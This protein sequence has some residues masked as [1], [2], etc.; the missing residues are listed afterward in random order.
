MKLPSNSFKEAILAGRRQ[1]GFWLSLGSAAVAEV[2]AGAGYD[3]VMIDA[4]H[5][6]NDLTTVV[7]QLRVLEGGSATPVVR[8]AWNDPVLIKRLLDAGAPTLLV[9]FVRNADE[10]A[11][12]V[13]ATRYPPAGIRGV[14]TSQR[15]SRWGQRADYVQSYEREL[16]VIV[17]LETASSLAALEAIALVPGIDALFIGPSDLAADMGHLGEPD[18]PEVQAAIASAVSR[19]RR[20]GKPMGTFAPAV[21]DAR[22]YLELG[23]TFAAV[24]ADAGVLRRGAETLLTTFR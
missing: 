7:D 24:G 3:W 15:A 1:I 4:E 12:A 9:P 13:A 23:M 10:A 8:P 6:P 2:I 22:R 14:A 18:H 19:C 5:G 16:C 21:D 17:Q 11:Q 20:A